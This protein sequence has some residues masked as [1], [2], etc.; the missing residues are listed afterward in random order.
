MFV[1]GGIGSLTQAIA[2]AATT[3]G[4]QIRTNSTI[5]SITVRSGK[6]TAVV[7]ANGE[8]IAAAAVVS[9]ADPKTTYLRL[10]DPTD[11]DPD[12]RF[13]IQNYKSRGSAAKVNLAL[14]SLPSFTSIQEPSQLSGRIHVGPDIDYMER[15][16]DSAKYGDFSPHPY[17]DVVIPSL[18]DPAL[19]PNGAHVMSIYAQYAP[20]ALRNGDWNGRR[21][22]LGDAVV[23]TLAEYAPNIRS[24]IVARQVLTPLDL[25]QTYG[26]FGGQIFHGE[27]SLDQLFTFRPV[28][29]F[30]Q[31]RTP[32][33]NLYLCG[34]GTHPGGGVTGGPGVNA[35]REIINDLKAQK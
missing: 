11:L 8:E 33:Q 25:E 10:L 27:P 3:A 1:K 7:L 5:Q 13:R 2:K 30:A 12:F 4:A 15:A 23:N 29:G 6:A 31:Y 26:L 18:S 19:A 32:I 17:M 9:N 14:S 22:E 21:E 24:L 20:Y 35:S 34:A 16:F 28:L